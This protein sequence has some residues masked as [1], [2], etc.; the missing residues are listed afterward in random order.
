MQ[1]ADVR[2]GFVAPPQL[3]RERV[4]HLA[5]MHLQGFFYLITY[6]ADHRTGGFMPGDLGWLNEASRQDWGNSLQ[7]G[8]AKLTRTWL[9]RVEG[10]G[11]D[12]F[13]KI[14]IRREPSEADLWSFAI[15]WNKALR[16]IGFFGDL[17][18]AQIH[19]NT[20][21][22]LTWQRIDATRRMRRET[23]LD[24]ADDILFSPVQTST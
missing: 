7:L 8:F 23:S 17:E 4:R 15:E 19:V 6:D 3:D 5:H 21:P 12:G 22:P 14:A 18:R 1:S 9:P 20:I 24:P 13:F 16:S 2:F 11:T 10:A